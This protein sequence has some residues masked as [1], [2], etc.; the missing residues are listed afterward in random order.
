MNKTLIVEVSL[1][2][3]VVFLMFASGVL[4][5]QLRAAD[6]NIKSLAESTKSDM[7]LLKSELQTSINS[8]HEELKGFI[9]NIEKGLEASRTE[10]KDL[11][12]SHETRTDV[13]QKIQSLEI[14]TKLLKSA[15]DSLLYMINASKDNNKKEHEEMLAVLN[16]I[17]QKLT[18][19]SG[20]L[21]EARE[22]ASVEA[23]ILREEIKQ[24]SDENKLMNENYDGLLKK[25]EQKATEVPVSPS[26]CP[27]AVE[28]K[29]V[30][31]EPKVEKKKNWFIRAFRKVF[32]D[33]T[34]S[35]TEVVKEKPP[36]WFYTE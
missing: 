25:I 30:V 26:V 17:G 31:V 6:S 15:N 10:F 21:K 28:T 3:L 24:L 8:S 14:D 36:Y 1:G 11:L 16:I 35:H 4:Y 9:N 22:A 18:I 33:K 29:P 32:V 12:A 5:K 13:T 27:Q 20:E 23:N 34:H 19:L 7:S 2:I